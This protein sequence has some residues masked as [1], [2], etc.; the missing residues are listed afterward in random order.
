MDAEWGLGAA[1]EGE[2]WGRLTVAANTTPPVDSNVRV[3]SVPGGGGS[4][5]SA[6]VTSGAGQTKPG[7]TRA[8]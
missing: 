2:G 4:A 6:D 7:E 1:D 5:A 3:C 8:D